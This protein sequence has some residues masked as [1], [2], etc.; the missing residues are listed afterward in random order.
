MHLSRFQKHEYT[1]INVWVLQNWLQVDE[2]KS[3]IEFFFYSQVYIDLEYAYVFSNCTYY[4]H[5]ISKNIC[6]N[7]F[8][9]HID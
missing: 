4:S 7:Y 6:R 9:H 8:E 2:S 5:N 1:C 3:N